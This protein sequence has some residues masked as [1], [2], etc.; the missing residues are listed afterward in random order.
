MQEPRNINVG[1][2]GLGFMGR[3]HVAAFNRAS[4][5]QIVAVADRD[6]SRLTGD[7]DGEGNFDTG[8]GDRLF[9]PGEVSTCEDA[10]ELIDHPDVELVSITTPTPTHRELALAV[11]HSGRHLLVEKPVDLDPAVILEISAAA[12]DA[13]VLAMP[14]HCMRFWPAWAWMKARIDEQQ[15]GSVRSAKFTRTGAA[16]GWNPS[17]YLDDEKS[18]GAVVDLHIHDTDFIIHCFGTPRSVQSSG[19]RRHLKTSYE[20]DGG[21]EVVAEGGWLEPPDAPFTMRAVIECSEATIEFDLAA[22]PEVSVR[23]PDGRLE[24]HPEASIGGSGYDGEV[25]AIVDAIQRGDTSPPV[26]LEDAAET[27]RVLQAEIRSLDSEGERIVI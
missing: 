3:T 24:P 18:G 12:R 14:A 27:G 2:I 13:G 23:F 15:Y 25:Q 19:S 4:G 7:S 20:F 1:V 9:D 8:A 6:R 26:T 22:E 10:L 16:P 17:F 11:I 5:C 21:P